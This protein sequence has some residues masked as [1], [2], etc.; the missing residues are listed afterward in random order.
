MRNCYR[1]Q[2]QEFQKAIGPQLLFEITWAKQDEFQV[3]L[4]SRISWEHF[5]KAHVKDQKI[6]S[7]QEQSRIAQEQR[8]IAQKQS[9]LAQSRAL[10]GALGK[11]F[12]R[13]FLEL[14]VSPRSSRR[15]QEDPR[16]SLEKPGGPQ[17]LLGEAGRTPGAPERGRED[18][19]SSLSKLQKGLTELSAAT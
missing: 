10:F 8:R 9:K 12:C 18:L 15:G 11:P 19:G 17:D 16:S 14:W 13:S 6:R 4:P 3:T 7:A 2:A 1:R 5:W